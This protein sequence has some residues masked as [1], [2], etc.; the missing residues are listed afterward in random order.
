[1][2][3]KIGSNEIK[4]FASLTG[5]TSTKVSSP[6]AFLPAP[7][8]VQTPPSE[9]MP[10]LQ[11]VHNAESPSS[12]TQSPCSKEADDSVRLQ[13]VTNVFYVSAASSRCLTSADTP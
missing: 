2:I 5:L 3:L 13:Y 10:R 1:M 4:P 7:G 8:A 11:L 9:E 12:G 6:P